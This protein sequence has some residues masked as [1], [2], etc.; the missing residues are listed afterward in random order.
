MKKQCTANIGGNSGR[1]EKGAS[2]SGDHA[3]PALKRWQRERQGRGERYGNDRAECGVKSKEVHT[4]FAMR[5]IVKN[6]NRQKPDQ[7]VS[8]TRIDFARLLPPAESCKRCNRRPWHKP[9][10]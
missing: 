2:Q 1:D 5:Q 10:K 8:E 4:A 6:K 7:E 3:G 9:G